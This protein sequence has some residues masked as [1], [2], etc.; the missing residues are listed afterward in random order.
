[1]NLAKAIGFTALLV[2]SSLAG[3][4]QY[5]GE[6]AQEPQFFGE[7]YWQENGV[8]L[9]WENESVYYAIP[10]INGSCDEWGIVFDVEGEDPWNWKGEEK[11][12]LCVD[13]VRNENHVSTYT[14][15]YFEI[16]I[17][18]DEDESNLCYEIHIIEGGIIRYYEDDESCFPQ[19]NEIR[20]PNGEYG[21]MW[22]KGDDKE[23]H[24]EFADFVEDS[25]DAAEQIG[26]QTLSYAPVYLMDQ[27][28]DSDDDIDCGMIWP[29]DPFEAAIY[30]FTAE[31]ELNY[32][33]A[34]GCFMDNYDDQSY[35]NVALEL[36]ED[37][38]SNQ[39][40][41][42][43]VQDWLDTNAET[44]GKES[45]NL[46]AEFNISGGGL[47]YSDASYQPQPVD[48]DTS[49]DILTNDASN[50]SIFTIEENPH[51]DQAGMA[52]FTKYVEVFGLGIYA[53]SGL[54]DAQVLHAADVFAE[55]LDN[56]EDGVVDDQALLSRL[57]NMSALI[58]MFNSEEPD[59][60]PALSDFMQ[61]YNGNGESAVLF[62]D[63]VDPENPGRWGS[64]ATI[65]EI[66]HTINHIG[67]VSV[68]PEAFALQPN[69]SLLSEAM[70]E[71]RGGRF[72]DHPGDYPEDAWYHYDDTTCDY[73]CM[74]IEYIYW[75]QVTNMNLLNDTTTC[76]EIA[77]EWEPCSGELLES[78]DVLIHALITDPQYKLPQI[79]PDGIYN[80]E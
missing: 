29:E 10:L 54:S 77:D 42:E 47:G 1:M 16:C 17:E 58:P 65:E 24:E 30:S 45:F 75:A 66:M 38:S 68:Y 56:D 5:F 49:G 53:E 72:I 34:V 57:Q 67:H 46:S 28:D 26:C 9:I 74:A 59:D 2:L 39:I 48:C 22:L 52:C 69:S 31:Y 18:E 79:A 41:L 25:E 35:E 3:C 78:M 73:E 14:G 64:D 80:P 32:G 70:D 44:Y 19:S 61:N 62:A 36:E 23:W 11:D 33:A 8:A 51:A 21:S 43:Y 15:D 76:D 7:L 13:L 55:L 63:E 37:Y 20:E 4:V 6:D 50:S 71:A 12:G 27:D 40:A 60:S